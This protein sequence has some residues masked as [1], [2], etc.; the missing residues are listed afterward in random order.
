MLATL[1]TVLL[2]F[3][4]LLCQ[5]GDALAE[6]SAADPIIPAELHGTWRTQNDGGDELRVEAERISLW[7][8]DEPAFHCVTRG[9]DGA[10]V[11]WTHSGPASW[12]LT[13]DGDDLLLDR[14]DGAQRFHRT[15]SAPHTEEPKPMAL[16]TRGELAEEKVDALKKELRERCK[17]DQEVRKDPK[18]DDPKVLEEMGRVDE[19]NTAWLRG[20]VAEIG[21]IDAETFGGRAADDAF[22]LVQHSGDMPMM[23]AA[24]P[25]I[26]A[27]LKKKGGDAQSYALLLD[28]TQMRLGYRQR[29]GS[30]LVM[31]HEGPMYLF[32]LEDPEHVEDRR[33]AIKLFP[34]TTYLDII[35]KN[36]ERPVVR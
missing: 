29:Y 4:G 28:R 26:E 11:V 30:Q 6:K 8:E 33:K 23:R 35:E 20:V 7:H 15:G 32:P 19:D 34:L 1:T 9:D 22:L 36:Y 2:L 3:P 17:R 12:K 5:G 25:L 24:L 10:P 18:M 13:R 14:G 27:E 31:G 21:W 16:G